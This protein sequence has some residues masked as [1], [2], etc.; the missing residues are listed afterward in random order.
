MASV[1]WS[2]SNRANIRCVVSR[3]IA[4]PEYRE[5]SPFAFQDYALGP[6]T[7]GNPNL[8][9]TYIMNYDLRWELYPQPGQLVAVSVFWKHF[10]DPIERVVS[11]GSSGSRNTFTFEN[12]AAAYD[13]GVEIEGRKSLEF[14]SPALSGVTLGGNMT[15]V[16]SHVRIVQ[17]GGTL[18]L[19][20]PLHGQSPYTVNTVLSYTSQR[21]TTELSLLYNVFGDRLIS[22]GRWPTEPMYEKS[23]HQLDVTFGQRLWQGLSLKASAKN[24]LDARHRVTQQQLLGDMA[25]KEGVVKDYRLGLTYG[26]G[27]TYAL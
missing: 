1:I 9:T 15:F 24:L 10:K 11:L 14:L 13:R 4:R 21:A 5:L 16:N 18:E 8:R 2:V 23:R 26:V 27:L 7:V 20:R 12:S 25:G 22:A 17:G 3:T 19:N 6:L